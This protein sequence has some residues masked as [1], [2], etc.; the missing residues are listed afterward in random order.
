MLE[1]LSSAE[2]SVPTRGT[3]RNIP[4][5]DIL[6]RHRRENLKSYNRLFDTHYGHITLGRMQ[7]AWQLWPYNFYISSK[8]ESGLNTCKSLLS[9]YCS[10]NISVP[11]FY[12]REIYRVTT[13]HLF[14]CEPWPSHAITYRW[15][16]ATRQQSPCLTLQCHAMIS[17][18][19]KYNET[20]NQHLNHKEDCVAGSKLLWS[21][22]CE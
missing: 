19:L 8:Y 10:Y 15:V 2:T 22:T 18:A 11:Y 12:I 6:H 14:C 16:W 9:N 21:Y 20:E 1:A 17:T 7:M 5:D 13:H 3:W 4:E